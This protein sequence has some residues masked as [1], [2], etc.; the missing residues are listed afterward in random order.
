MEH[1]RQD[2]IPGILSKGEVM[3][4]TGD[5]AAEVAFYLA[6]SVRQGCW[7]GGWSAEHATAEVDFVFH[8]KSGI[9]PVEVKAEENLKAKSLKVYFEK[10]TPAI[11]IRSSMSDYRHDEWLLNLPLYGISQILA[12]CEKFI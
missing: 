12:E 2:L 1:K 9:Y 8:Y 10:Y 5:H 3:L 6:I 11:A 4:I 7:D